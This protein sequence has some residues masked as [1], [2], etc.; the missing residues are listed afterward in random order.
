L[1]FADQIGW[2]GGW[3]AITVLVSA[4]RNKQEKR[5][6]VEKSRENCFFGNGEAQYLDSNS[7]EASTNLAG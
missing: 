4:H 6:L 3:L 2:R 1:R 5:L 7:R